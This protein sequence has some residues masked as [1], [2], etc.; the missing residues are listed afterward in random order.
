LHPGMT[1]LPHLQTLTVTGPLKV[2]GISETPSRK[3]IF[4]CRPEKPSDEESCAKTIVSSL[5]TTAFRRQSTPEDLESLMEMY[6]IGR[7]EGDFEAGIRTA[8]QAIIAKPE[9]VYRMAFVPVKRFG[10]RI[11][12]WHRDCLTSSGAR[13]RTTN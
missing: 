11:Q 9:F 8:I 10:F 1:T 2:T 13:P 6:K 7:A 4:A 12:N 3:R 5:S